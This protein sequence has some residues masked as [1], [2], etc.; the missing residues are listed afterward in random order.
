MDG[1]DASDFATPGLIFQVG[2]PPRRIDIINTIEGVSFD[3]ASAEPIVVH[4][5][6]VDVRVIGLAALIKNKETV[7]RPEDLEDARRLRANA[8]RSTQ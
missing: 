7:A 2:V 1:L 8:S 3:E 6:N 5:G 4:V